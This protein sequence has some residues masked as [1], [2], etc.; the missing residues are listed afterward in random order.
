MGRVRWTR[1]ADSEGIDKDLVLLRG[2]DVLVF[3][4]EAVEE[5]LAGD[6]R[7]ED[8]ILAAAVDL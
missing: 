5:G 4:L 8:V 6:V 2:R 3:R 7:G 1:A